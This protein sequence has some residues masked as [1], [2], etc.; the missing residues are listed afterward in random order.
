MENL[1]RK[2]TYDELINY[3]ELKQPK[4]KYPNR[5]ATFLRN[6]P[7]LSQFDGDSWIDMEEQQNNINKEKLKEMEVQRIASD[8]GDTAQLLRHPVYY[9]IAGTSGQQTP[10]D[11]DSVVRDYL[12]EMEQADQ[13]EAEQRH[14][15]ISKGKQMLQDMFDSLQSLVPKPSRFTRIT[16][17]KQQVQELIDKLESMKIEPIPQSVIQQLDTVQK[18]LNFIE[19]KTDIPQKQLKEALEYYTIDDILSII[20][21]TVLKPTYTKAIQNAMSSGAASSSSAA[22][23]AATSS[24]GAASSSS[25]APATASSN[26][27]PKYKVKEEIVYNDE[28]GY[29]M[30]DM[31]STTDL[32]FQFHLRG[33]DTELPDKDG[34][35]QKGKGKENTYKNRVIN[36]IDKLIQNG[37]WT[38]VVNDKLLKE[39]KAEWFLTHEKTSK[40][41]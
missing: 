39:R 8:R 5:N 33:L 41:T 25:A 14:S 13:E 3:L 9:S 1:R 19:E 2:P 34:T 12:D 21:S 11:Y 16:S 20:T 27:G 22:P 32:E 10:E 17:T 28:I 37:R 35:K 23:A 36:K 30:S 38:T 26:R 24:S 40:A 6:S 18:K 15:A 29:W 31:I 4:I 7:Y